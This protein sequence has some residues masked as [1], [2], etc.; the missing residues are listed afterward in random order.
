MNQHAHKNVQ[1]GSQKS[2][3]LLAFNMIHYLASIGRDIILTSND[4]YE[5]KG[6]QMVERSTYTQ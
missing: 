4:L 2:A 1:M 5:A 6:N 3:L